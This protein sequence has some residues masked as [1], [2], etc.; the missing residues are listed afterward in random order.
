VER[1]Y[2][3][4]KDLPLEQRPVTDMLASYRSLA[5]DASLSA[6]ART[7]ARNR[8]TLLAILEKQSAEITQ[9]KQATSD[10]ATRQ[11]ELDGQARQIE[12]RLQT[13]GIA[14]YTAV[15]E[16]RM[17]S[18]KRADNQPLLRLVD[19]A[20]GRTLVYIKLTDA[21]QQTLIEKFVG[22]KGEVARDPQ[23][24]VDVIEPSDMQEVNAD[25]V[26]HGVTARIYPP[27][28]SHSKE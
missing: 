24:S 21:K 2:E 16:L 19:P 11:A 23:L 20:D 10:F 6:A 28:L 18:I 1:Q 26:F 17:S 7:T 27:S 12:Q 13:A 9:A 5:D 14:N 22:L 8:V 25:K 4:T 15:G 3:S